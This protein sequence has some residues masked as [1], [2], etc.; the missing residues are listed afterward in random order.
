MR[1][2]GLMVWLVVPLLLGTTTTVVAGPHDEQRREVERAWQARQDKVRSVRLHC[3]EKC[4]DTRGSLT[5]GMPIFPGFPNPYEGKIVPPEDH[6]FETK[7]ELFVQGDRE[8]RYRYEDEYWDLDTQRYRRQVCLEV[9]NEKKHR[10]F[11]AWLEGETKP[12]SSVNNSARSFPNTPQLYPLTAVYRGMGDR[13]AAFRLGEFTPGRANVRIR[14]RPCAEWIRGEESG[15]HVRLF[16]DPS[17]DHV[18]VRVQMLY[19]QRVLM[20]FDMEYRQHPE[21]DWCPTEWRYQLNSTREKGRILHL[22]HAVV[23]TAVF[24]EPIESDQFE[25]P[26]PPGT[27][28]VD[29]DTNTDYIVKPTGTYP[30]AD[31]DRAP[32]REAMLAKTLKAERAAFWQRALV[33]GVTFLMAVIVGLIAWQMFNRRPNSQS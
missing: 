18:P 12:T 31:E 28:V 30:I 1:N 26:Y 6:T 20:Q 19:G 27:I 2:T 23:E 14:Q 13:F 22:T 33:W 9:W 4:T 15:S 7:V 17:R 5:A 10:R 32:T 8:L 11:T 24:N 25:I 29:G 21:A 16:L 3:R